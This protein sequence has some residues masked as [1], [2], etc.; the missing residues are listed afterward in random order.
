[1]SLIVVVVLGLLIIGAV[2]YG[3]LISEKGYTGPFSSHFNGNKF[4]NLMR[5]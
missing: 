1:M 3:I 4:F 2:I 5:D